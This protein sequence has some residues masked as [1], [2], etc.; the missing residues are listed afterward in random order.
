[1]DDKD[2]IDSINKLSN[3]YSVKGNF[4][5]AMKFARE[6]LLLAKTTKDKEGQAKAYFSIGAVYKYQFNYPEA[7]KHYFIA[8]HLMKETGNKKNI[9]F[10]YYNIAGLYYIQGNY[11]E[12]LKN[13][14]E[15]LRHYEEAKDKR[16][17][18]ACLHGIG[19]VY[20]LL[21]N[22]TEAERHLLKGL[23]VRKEIG[24]RFGVAQSYNS[25]GQVYANKG[26]YEGALKN[27]LAAMEIF[28]EPGAPN[29]GIPFSYFRIGSVYKKMGEVAQ[30]KKDSGSATHLFTR[31]LENFRASSI[32]SEKAG[33]KKDVADAYVQ[34][35][36]VNLMLKKFS[37]AGDYLQKALDISIAV[38]DKEAAKDS[39][40]SLSTLE[41]AQG[42]H[43]Q[44]LSAYK[45]YIL[46]RD[47]LLNDEHTR[48]SI[49]AEI[50]YNLYKEEAEEQRKKNQRVFVIGSL[51]LLVLVFLLVAYIQ[52]RHSE[53]KQKANALLLLQ[54]EE[55]QN[56]LT[57][58]KTTQAQLVQR[59]KMA[60]LGE[61]T[62]GIAHEI[63]NPLNFVNNFSEV[64]IELLDELR[65]GPF[66]QIPGEDK[67]EADEMAGAL[68]DNLQKISFHGKRA[69]A[70]V[71]SMLQ[72]SRKSNGQKEPVDINALAEEYLRISYNGLRARD[73]TFNVKL[74]TKL[75]PSIGK[76]DVIPQD[77]GR[78]LLNLYNNACYSVTQK[79]KS[80]NGTFEPLV[81]L[82]TRKVGNMVEIGIKDNGTGIP[83]D[84]LDK[85]YQ[86]FFTTKP[87]GQGTGLGLSLSYDIITKGHG[88]ELEVETKEGEYA[89][90]IIRL[91]LKSR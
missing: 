17:V 76:V 8:L 56:T 70:I 87:S 31:A 5:G 32:A 15:A 26:N 30:S 54:K 88:G 18:A 85:I 12:H 1:M 79:K 20:L 67:R 28:R 41:S 23:E 10:A 91:P 27:H 39:Y 81:S 62:A 47:S 84:V 64:S 55:L 4:E 40:Y 78:V 42:N 53:Q 73:K 77:I 90:F 50:K 29:W 59:E 22:N 38:K 3:S 35:G 83:S 72:H 51:I 37:T 65:E 11:G 24:D 68:T 69:D 6:A 9:A 34:L 46:Y 2:K 61:L 19:T 36:N 45:N 80:L 66:Q 63:Q 43:E 13:Q 89:A 86:P 49:Q 21:N 16:G 14:F 33:N 75:D 58:L 44:A 48:E 52:W 7:F 74:E 60:S 57:E 71:K 82:T 25:I